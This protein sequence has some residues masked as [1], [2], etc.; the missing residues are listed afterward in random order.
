[1]TQATCGNKKTRATGRPTCAAPEKKKG[2]RRADTGS[3]AIADFAFFY[4]PDR[5]RKKKGKGGN[6]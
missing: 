4:A 1:M 2:G 5:G 6:A 3:A